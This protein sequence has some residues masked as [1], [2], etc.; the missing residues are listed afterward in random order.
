MDSDCDALR[1]VLKQ[2]WTVWLLAV[3]ARIAL[4]AFWPANRARFERLGHLPLDDDDRPDQPSKTG[5]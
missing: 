2:F 1:A 4:Y 5:R 3:F